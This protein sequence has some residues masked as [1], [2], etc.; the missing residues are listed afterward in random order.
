M[1]RKFMKKGNHLWQNQRG[2][3]WIFVVLLILI[4][5]LL[6]LI[7][8]PVYRQ[9][10]Y[11]ADEIGCTTALKTA[12]DQ[13]AIAC[14]SD[15]ELSAEEA[16]EVVSKAMG[17]WDDLCV[18]H[19]TIYLVETKDSEVPY[20][21]VCGLHDTDLKEKTRLNASHVL[22]QIQSQVKSAQLQGERYPDRITVELNGKQYDAVLTEE[23]SRFRSTGLLTESAEDTEIYY[24]LTG[25]GSGESD[26]E[27]SESSVCDFSYTEKGYCVIWSSKDGWFEDSFQK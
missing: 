18:G 1:N 9:Y 11:H 15:A 8:I 25:Y 27:A 3:A 7:F 4:L 16:K 19:G 14:L 6:I 21:V 2:I 22:K 23:K 13:L 17:G 26:S 10:R 5:A 20:E 12:N 24:A